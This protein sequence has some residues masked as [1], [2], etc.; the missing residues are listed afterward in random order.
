MTPTDSEAPVPPVFDTESEHTKIYATA[1]SP[2]V[3]QPHL[4]AVRPYLHVPPEHLPDHV[5]VAHKNLVEYANM[6]SANQK[7]YSDFYHYVAQSLFS[8]DTKAIQL[9]TLGSYYTGCLHSDDECA[10][11]CAGSLPKDP[12]ALCDVNIYKY[13]P[14]I[15]RDKRI[16]QLHKQEHNTKAILY[17]PASSDFYGLTQE[18][19]DEL[20]KDGSFLINVR[21]YDEESAMSM[22]KTISSPGFPEEYTPIKHLVRNHVVLPPSPETTGKK[23]V[24]TSKKDTT[25]DESETESLSGLQIAVIVLVVLLVLVILLGVLFWFLR[26]QKGRDWVT[27][28]SVPAPNASLDSGGGMEPLL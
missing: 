23:E 8:G 24:K 27:K 28:W 1:Y 14:N 9:G 3:I 7:Q 4:D 15:S 18:D 26:S 21:K 17:V 6:Y 11:N 12:T 5:V 25:L 19:A 10:P 2:K 16:T 13:D 22:R 20:I